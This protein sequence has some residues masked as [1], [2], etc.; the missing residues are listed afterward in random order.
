MLDISRERVDHEFDMMD[1][2]KS[3]KLSPAEAKEVSE[4]LGIRN[5]FRTTLGRR[6]QK[7]SAFL[8]SAITNGFVLAERKR[9]GGQE[10]QYQ[11]H[12]KSTNTYTVL[13][14]VE[15][16]YAKWLSDKMAVKMA[17]QQIIQ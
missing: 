3:Q 9:H 12:D 15:Y 6:Y 14:E 13:S 8:K 16:N 17:I 10:V 7:R 5:L 1:Y 4:Y 2:A 11:L